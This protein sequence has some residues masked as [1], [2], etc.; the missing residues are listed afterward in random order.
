MKTQIPRLALAA[1]ALLCATGRLTE[2]AP[3]A[4][5]PTPLP[6][7]ITLTSGIITTTLNTQVSVTTVNIG[8]TN[9]TVEETVINDFNTVLAQNTWTIQP[10]MAA[11]TTALFEL[12]DEVRCV[13]KIVNAN[14]RAQAKITAELIL[15]EQNGARAFTPLIYI[16]STEFTPVP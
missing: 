14:Q 10:G 6:P 9:L 16:P 5:P 15:T 1:F 12:V 13:V 8:S 2:A 3:G 4:P 7:S 11:S